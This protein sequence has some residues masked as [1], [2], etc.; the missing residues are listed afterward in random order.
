MRYFRFGV[1][2]SLSQSEAGLSC[3]SRGAVW[4]KAETRI[5]H[6]T[7][8]VIPRQR[9]AFEAGVKMKNYEL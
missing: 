7:R 9:A 4:E 5:F 8:T 1:C 6:L 2:L 3:A